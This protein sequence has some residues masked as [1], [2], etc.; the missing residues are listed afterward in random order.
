MP[1]WAATLP[2]RQCRGT[3]Y[4]LWSEDRGYHIWEINMARTVI[5]R[6]CQ[7]QPELAVR[8]VQPGC[9][10]G[11]LIDCNNI[12]LVISAPSC[13]CLL[14]SPLLFTGCWPGYDTPWEDNVRPDELPALV[15]PAFD[16]NDKGETVF[17]FDDK[18]YKMPPGRY[19][20]SIELNDGRRLAELD[21][22]L[23]TQPV[24]IDSVTVTSK[25]CDNS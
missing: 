17:R 20:G 11:Q 5:T 14:K 7:G 12:R 1:G 18:L 10:G 6:I 25:T 16:I 8:L 4:P 13:P 9:D 3:P 24:I 22:D 15:Y 2:A 19:I 23:C 21:I